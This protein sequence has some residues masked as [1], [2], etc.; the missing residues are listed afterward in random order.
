[1]PGSG[2]PV[3]TTLIPN[4]VQAGKVGI[5]LGLPFGTGI[6]AGT[7]QLVT[8]RFDVS[9]AA[10]SGQTL[11]TFGDQPVFRE[12][13]DVNAN[14]VPATFQNGSLNILGPTAAN[15]S[16]GGRVL[17]ASGSGVSNARVVLTDANGASR[18]S[19]TNSF[20]YYRFTEVPA[21]ETCVFSVRHKEYQF[22]PQV[23]TITDNIGE[24]NF[25]AE[26]Y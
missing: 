14:P 17:T 11:L 7:R 9:P 6:T 8:I 25:T 15:V 2:I 5:V 3:G 12:I 20:G 13:V 19:L 24:L 22:A 18:T 26:N 10:S 21:G 16:V 1:L 23:L 4:T